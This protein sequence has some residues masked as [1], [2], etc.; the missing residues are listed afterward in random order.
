MEF[1]GKVWKDGNTW[2]IE[3]PSLNLMTQ[4]KSKKDAFKMIRDA[5]IGLVECYFESE[6]PKKFDITVVDYSKGSF[7]LTSSDNKLLL[8]LSL[9]RQREKSGSTI[10]ETVARLGAKSPHAYAQYERGKTS[11]SLEQYE[12]LMF[13]VNPKLTSVLRIM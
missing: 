10:R 6:T 9:K 7:G 1:E 2:L 3:V 12:R 5:A 11:I 8:A 13:A 4:G